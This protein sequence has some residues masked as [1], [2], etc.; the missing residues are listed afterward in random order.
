MVGRPFIKTRERGD[1]IILEIKPP[2]IT[3]VEGGIAETVLEIKPPDVVEL[4]S[5]MAEIE[6]FWDEREVING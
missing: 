5:G 1:L 2:D 3:E 4:E 6:L